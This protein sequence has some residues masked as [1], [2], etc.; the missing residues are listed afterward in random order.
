[1]KNLQLTNTNEP[2]TGEI[3]RALRYCADANSIC[4]DA[5]P[6]HINYAGCRTVLIKNAADRL[7][8]QEREIE[9]LKA[10]AFV[11]ALENAER[12]AELT[13]RAESAERDKDAA[14]DLTSIRIMR[15]IIEN[16]VEIEE[17]ND[18]C[19]LCEHH[20]ST[21][22]KCGSCYST[23][24]FELRKDCRGLQPHGEERK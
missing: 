5:C 8:N 20:C 24:N 2:T 9:E 1:M 13:A 12:I 21:H 18:P 17:W 10:D 16:D 23:E 3:V 22:G 11:N 6:A 15:Y 19:K 7:E 14:I 4:G